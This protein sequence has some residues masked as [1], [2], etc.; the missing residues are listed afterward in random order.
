MPKLKPL[1]DQ[2]DTR[3]TESS[4]RRTPGLAGYPPERSI[5]AGLEEIK[6]AHNKE[7]WFTVKR[8]GEKTIKSLSF[9][10]LPPSDKYQLYCY[11][12]DAYRF[13]G[14]FSR[15]LDI[16][17]K[18]SLLASKRLKPPYNAMI[19]SVL[20]LNF[21]NIG[22]INQALNQF[23]KVEQYYQECGDKLYPMDTS[24]RFYNLLGLGYV[25]LHKDELDEVKETIERKLPA[26]LS[27]LSD[28]DIV[29]EYY[30]L[31]GEYLIAIKNYK[32]ARVSFWESIKI[33]E[34]I[35]LPAGVITAKIHLAIID[36]IENQKRFAIQNLQTIL[37]DAQRLKLNDI[38][39]EVG[40]LL[41]KCYSLSGFPDKAIII[42]NRIKPIL[43]KLDTV[44]LYEKTREFDRL[45]QQL[46]GKPKHI[47]KFIPKILVQ[48]LDGRYEKSADKYTIVG[49]HPAMQEIYHLIEK[50]A[51]TDLPVLIQGETGTGKELIA[52]AIHN[53]S[54]RVSKTY[55]PFNC[56]ALPET[57]IESSL[58]GHTKGAFTGAIEEKKGYIE[59]ASGGTLFIDEIANMSPSM[60][61][62]LL[63]VLEEK[64]LWRVG[65]SKPIQ[66][67]TRFI[68][69]SNQD[70]EQ[71]VKRKLFREDLFYRI[72]T[73]VINLPPL[74]DRKDDIPLLAQHFLR[75][76]GRPSSLVSPSALSLF[77]AYPWPGNIRELENEIKRIC[78]LYPDVKVIEE[79]MLSDTIRNYQPPAH[80]PKSK[81]LKESTLSY[82]RKF[83]KDVLDSCNGNITQ[84]AHLLACA[85]ANLC[86]KMKSLKL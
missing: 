25:Y 61:Q 50:I 22:N 51:P 36:L 60:Q 35:N 49:N 17:Y 12:G 75:K 6:S 64:L 45:Y 30:H 47:S 65:A 28:K 8:L 20:G 71:L 86:R 1:A 32:D 74:R 21:L 84:A 62:K 13:L 83:I 44:W 57:L 48:T 85:P 77:T 63:R 76:Y 15:S 2:P 43:S 27:L 72:N 26:Y 55:F 81:S 37:K 14:E 41:S 34:Q 54:R 59:L 11:L 66:I 73:I 33:G 29:M 9:N 19:F 79:S 24:R 70:I 80:P 31:K 68:F 39:C 69:A 3:P 42:E 56:G 67:D 38:V 10:S 58:F 40:L 7:N 46:Q 4:G 78:A 18:A 82:Q 52:S 53:N 23:K 5:R 16:Y